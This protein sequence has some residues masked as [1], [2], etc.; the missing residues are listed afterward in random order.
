MTGSIFC[1]IDGVLFHFEDNFST[2]IRAEELKP[3]REAIN[4]LIE[5]HR[6]GYKIILTTG[7]PEPTRAITEKQLYNAG[8]IYD[9]LVMGVGCGPR[10][11]IN[12]MD[13]EDN[14]PKAIAINIKRDGGL[15]DIKIP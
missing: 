8:M 4:K 3:C 2:S 7:R 13:P 9:Q 14:I 15:K 5:W 1:D 11:L 10:Y 12:D 6:K